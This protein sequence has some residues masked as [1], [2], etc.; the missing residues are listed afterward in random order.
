MT[1]TSRC[2]HH[3]LAE[4][5][6]ECS[7]SDAELDEDDT[8]VVTPLITARALRDMGPC[9]ATE[10]RHAGDREPYVIQVDAAGT[11]GARRSYYCAVSIFSKPVSFVSCAILQ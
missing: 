3:Q 7:I 5:V 6:L 4:I 2:H 8:V 11:L 9:A 1:L 10:H